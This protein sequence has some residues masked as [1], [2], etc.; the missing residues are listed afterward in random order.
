MTLA[1]R[2]KR[3][4]RESEAVRAVKMKR[5]GQWRSPCH[6]PW[7]YIVDSSSSNG[8]LSSHPTPFSVPI[9]AAEHSQWH[10]QWWRIKSDGQSVVVANKDKGCSVLTTRTTHIHSCNEW[11]SLTSCQHTHSQQCQ[12]LVEMIGAHPHPNDCHLLL[13]TQAKRV[14]TSNINN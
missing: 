9:A 4:L 10:W 6:H 5:R 14:F 7:W 2:G 11:V 8:G 1:A 13:N 3:W 12:V